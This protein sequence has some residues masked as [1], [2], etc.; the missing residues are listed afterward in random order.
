MNAV[1]MSVVAIM[2]KKLLTE[3]ESYRN[4][5]DVWKRRAEAAEKDIRDMLV[6]GN[7]AICHFCKQDTNPDYLESC[8]ERGCAYVAEWRGPCAENGGEDIK[9]E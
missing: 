3:N 6:R 1:L 8:E 7:V 5:R 4:D 9:N 2:L